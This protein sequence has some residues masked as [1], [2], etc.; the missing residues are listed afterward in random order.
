[1]SAMGGLI[2]AFTFMGCAL[3]AVRIRVENS[4]GF[5]PSMG[6]PPPYPPPPYA[7]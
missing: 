1:M 6:M 4:S 3:D 5:M 2:W 7:F